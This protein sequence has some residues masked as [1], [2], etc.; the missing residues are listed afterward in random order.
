MGMF[1]MAF[2]GLFKVKVNSGIFFG[3]GGGAGVC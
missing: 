3:R 2:K 1:W